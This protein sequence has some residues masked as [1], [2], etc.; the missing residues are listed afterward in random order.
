MKTTDNQDELFIVVDKND[1]I[2]GYR[3]RKDCHTD[4]SLIHRST[5]IVIFN[6]KGEILLQ[7][8]SLTKDLYP[9]LYTVSAS[10]HVN[11]G[12][13]YT[14][15]ANREIYEEIGIKI[16]LKF[17]K[18]RFFEGPLETEFDAIFTANYD[19][20]FHLNTEEVE[21]V[22]YFSREKIRN[23]IDRLTPFAQKTFE[24][25]GIL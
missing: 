9:G 2:I 22:E 19:G 7:K 17:E 1:K 15:T 14:D 25:L 18:K 24:E 16:P 5:S 21:E 12:E 4:K 3:T 6:K 11:K 10:G 8:R 23:M 13:S 20:P